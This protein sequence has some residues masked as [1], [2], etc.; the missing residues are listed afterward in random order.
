MGIWVAVVLGLAA[1]IVAIILS[2]HEPQRYEPPKMRR[3]DHCWHRAQHITDLRG[4]RVRC[5]Q[6]GE[7]GLGPDDPDKCSDVLLI[8]EGPSPRDLLLA[9]CK[10][11]EEADG[12]QVSTERSEPLSPSAS[13]APKD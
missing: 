7:M 11:R 4:E 2:P 3:C 1:V 9:A 8:L 12:N 6:C 13:E 10:A 5:C